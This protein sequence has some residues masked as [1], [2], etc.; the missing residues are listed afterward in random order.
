MRD[1]CC[2]KPPK[3]F[4]DVARDAARRVAELITEL[5]ISQCPRACVD[6]SIDLVE[7]RNT[8]AYRRGMLVPVDRLA[9]LRKRERSGRN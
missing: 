5:E 1:L 7:S 6:E 4:T 8:H 2:A 9:L 3:S